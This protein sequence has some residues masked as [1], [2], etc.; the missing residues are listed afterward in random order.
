[1]SDLECYLIPFS[2]GNRDIKFVF[3][4]SGTE[5]INHKQVCFR[6]KTSAGCPRHLTGFPQALITFEFRNVITAQSDMEAGF[7][8][9][10]C[11]DDNLLQK[12]SA[13]VVIGNIDLSVTFA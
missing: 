4:E 6:T 13:C 12:V 7:H 8:T 1:M 5:V 3:A 2:H 11:V 9:F 10:L